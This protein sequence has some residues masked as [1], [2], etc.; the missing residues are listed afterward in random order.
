MLRNFA[1]TGRFEGSIYGARR[2]DQRRAARRIVA[3]A[4]PGYP[5]QIGTA[6]G[7]IPYGKGRI[8]FSTVDIADNLAADSGPA[9]VAREL[10][11]NSTRFAG[12]A[13]GIAS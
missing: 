13:G 4:S 2:D 7:V 10:F 5:M 3:G 8:V 9:D 1:G 11:C 6:V 12:K